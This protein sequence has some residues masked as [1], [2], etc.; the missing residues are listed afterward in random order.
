MKREEEAMKK[1]AA[2]M[3]AAAMAAAAAAAKCG[4]GAC[5]APEELRYPPAPKG[6]KLAEA[7]AMPYFKGD[8]NELIDR[9]EKEKKILVMS[10]GRRICTRCK[11][12]YELAEG[13]K[14][15]FDE[16]KC[17]YAKL[18]VDDP[19]QR[20]FFMSFCAPED[21]RLPYLGMYNPAT[22][23]S[24]TRTAGGTLEECREFFKEVLKPA[25]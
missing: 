15:E 2:M 14:L 20:Q 6:C 24:A 12:F 7:T 23:D 13:G 21:R 8:I 18:L 17:I 11:T 1:I 25:K 16:K 9:A 22:G 5:S 10:V 4:G 3:A 19:E